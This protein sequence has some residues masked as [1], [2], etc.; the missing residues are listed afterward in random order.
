MTEYAGVL[1]QFLSPDERRRF[2]QRSATRALAWL[3]PELLAWIAFTTLAIAPL[4]WPV[5]LIAA[6][7]AGTMTGIIFTVGHDASH[8]A[9]TPYRWLNEVIARIALIPSIH[10]A[11]LWDIG[12]NRIH[13]RFTNLMGADYVWE[14]MT[15]AQYAQA[16][17]L[18]RLLYR[19]YRS[20]FGHLP[21]YFIEMWWKKNFL[22]IAPETRVEWRRH[23]FDS[24]FVIIAQAL[25]IWGI[26]TAGHA[27]APQHSWLETLIFGWLIPF[28]HWNWLM[29][30]VIYMHHTHPD[31]G[32][33]DRAEDWTIYRSAI[34]GCVEARMP[35]LLDRLDNNIMRHQAHHAHPGIPMYS[36]GDAQDR[37][38][39][40]FPE[41]KRIKLTMASIAAS[42]RCC[43]LFDPEERRWR[44]F[45]G[46]ATT[47]PILLPPRHRASTESD[48]A[49]S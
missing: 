29:G 28:I 23:I 22:P 35:S 41:T 15:P 25:L 17:V 48:H 16:P 13:H 49:N 7:L 44:D 20:P 38:L 5:R 36:L 42:V 30:V 31:I 11:T 1:T 40:V 34:M 39:A 2:T 47:A 19:L 46:N 33:L 37:L 21:Y 43:K 8:H 26:I 3:V 32:W 9:L 27:L 12:H 6:I 4:P 18:R 24:L 14:P 45:N 10:S